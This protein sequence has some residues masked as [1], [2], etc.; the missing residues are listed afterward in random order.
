MKIKEDVEFYFLNYKDIEEAAA[1]L[2]QSFITYPLHQ[3][4]FQ[5]DW[6]KIDDFFQ[7]YFK[8]LLKSYFKS[9][10]IIVLGNPMRGICVYSLPDSKLTSILDYILAGFYQLPFNPSYGL[11]FS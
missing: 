11:N 4:I 3:Y 9:T 6:D 7:W 2:A 8:C 10:K 1:F 5:N